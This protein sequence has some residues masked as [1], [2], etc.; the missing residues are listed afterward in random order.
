MGSLAVPRESYSSLGSV[1]IIG[2]GRGKNKRKKDVKKKQKKKKN[3]QGNP[4]G[5]MSAQD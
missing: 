2:T 3:V 5:M 1:F 4:R